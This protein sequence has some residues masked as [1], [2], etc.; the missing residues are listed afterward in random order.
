MP[1]L[2]TVSPRDPG[3]TRRR[4]GKGFFY[5]NEFGQPL[6]PEDVERCKQ[7]VIPP[8]WQQ[9][10]IC[11][12]PNGHIQAVGTD[13]A[14]RRQYLY[15]PYWRLKRDQSKHD[16]VL[17]VAARLPTARRRVIKHLR[18]E[19]MPYERA[20]AAAFRLLDLGFFRVGGEAY[21]EA[22]NSYGLATIQK[23]HVSIQGHTVVF[24]YV[25]KSGQERYVALADNFVRA[26]V[27]DLLSRSDGG[28]ELLAYEDSTGWHDINS[29]E[30]NSYIKN[31]VGGEV[32]AKDFRTWHGT[33]IAEVSLAGAVQRSRTLSARK[34]A[35]STAMKEVAKYL[36]NTPTVARKSYVDPRVVDLFHDGVTIPPELAATDRE[37]HDGTTH[38]KI[39][40]A[41]LEILAS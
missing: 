22:N 21:A 24:D 15:H 35:V 1:R 23:E 31:V 2:R 8:A 9:V 3:W 39:E 6:A 12:A 17:T 16:R 18:M 25:A 27:R 36:G 33:V 19:G 26:A 10:W 34:R 29:T 37:L 14:G 30:I 13:D 20:L 28:P 41:V 32:S 7:L 38:G 11:P 5:L 40:R 4:A